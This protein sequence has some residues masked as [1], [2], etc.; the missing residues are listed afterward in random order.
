MRILRGSSLIV[1][2]AI[3]STV[4]AAELGM[5]VRGGTHGLGV[6]FGV[7][8]A[9]WVS[10]RVG[11]SALDVS[12]DFD[13]DDIEY[14]GDLELGGYGL[15]ADF[16][17]MNGMFR[18]TTGILS[19]R[20]A[21][22]LE[23]VPTDTIDIGNGSYDPSEVGTLYGDVEFDSTVPYF[24]VGWG[25]VARGKRFGFLCDIGAIWQGSGDV[26]L[27][28]TSGLVDPDDLAAE[29]EEIEEDI[30]DFEIWPV[31]TFGLAIRF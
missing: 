2:L 23:A 22:A 1:L 20:N 29:A 28:S 8:L 5:G 7:G 30:E 10:L 11:G 24:G 9:P 15:W 26:T 31:I 4:Q 16:F 6:D 21:L 12:G 17:P 18:L 19:N 14:D 3:G 13:E 25:N 27:A